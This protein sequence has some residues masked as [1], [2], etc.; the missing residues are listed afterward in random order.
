MNPTKMMILNWLNVLFAVLF[1]IEALVKFTADGFRF[2]F[3]SFWT[4]LDFIVVVVCKYF[5]YTQVGN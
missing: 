1:T 2:Y 5:M 3:T 4:L